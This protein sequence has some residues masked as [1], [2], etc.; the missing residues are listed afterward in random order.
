MKKVLLYEY[1]QVLVC[2]WRHMM[3]TFHSMK[4]LL[5]FSFSIIFPMWSYMIKHVIIQIHKIH[6]IIYIYNYI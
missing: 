3:S 4:L 6:I 2:F 1:D 5:S